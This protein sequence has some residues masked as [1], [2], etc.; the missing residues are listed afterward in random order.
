MGKLY[1]SYRDVE[2]MELREARV[3]YKEIAKKF[4][5]T[6]EAVR[7]VIT[8]FERDLTKACSDCG[9]TVTDKNK[10]A[11]RSSRCRLCY[12]LYLKEKRNKPHE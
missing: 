5:M 8:H 11:T 4:D 2:I 9:V 6:E 10:P 7:L 12:N 1:V 3:S